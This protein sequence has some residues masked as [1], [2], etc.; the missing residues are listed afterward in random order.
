MKKNIISKYSAER[1]KHENA[2]LMSSTNRWGYNGK[3]KQTVYGLNYLDYINRMYDPEIGR[4]F[5]Q[6]PLQEK[7]YSWSSY[8]YCFN[9]PINFVDPDGRQVV[10]L[11]TEDATKALNDFNTI[12][13]GEQF[14]KFRGLL[15]LDKKGTTFN[16]ISSEA[17]AAAFE[18]ITLTADQQA[19]VNEVTGA[20]NSKSVHKVE[21]VDING[22]VS[23]EGTKAFQ[24]HLNGQQAGFGDILVQ[25][26]NVR[27]ETM[28]AM[29]GGGINI[30][31]KK[32]SHSVIMEGTGVTHD[33]GRAVTTG[34][35]IVGHGVASANKV[36]GVDNNTR[37]I[38]VD[39]L[40]RRV[41]GITTFRDEHGGAKIV[42]PNA[43]P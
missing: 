13:A 39:N 14:E 9:N 12:F 10:G 4:W 38:R 37:A 3:E 31:T 41:M 11:T 2:N 22:T 42:N 26:G 6:D 28:N 29:S 33:G 7:H 30:P 20:I 34:H 15:T 35:E 21:Y 32:G 43:L 8:A 23:T 36:F 5:V 40:I 17:Q 27:G 18:G 1:G 25:S 19:L 16:S 24:E